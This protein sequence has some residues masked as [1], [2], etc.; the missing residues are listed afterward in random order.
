[1]I[2]QRCG[3]NQIALRGSVFYFE[4]VTSLS[5]FVSIISVFES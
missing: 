1:M 5:L 3:K 2:R 4:H